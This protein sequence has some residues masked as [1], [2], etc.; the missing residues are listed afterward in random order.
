MPF[1]RRRRKCFGS[2]SSDHLICNTSGFFGPPLRWLPIKTSPPWFQS[3]HP[4]GWLARPQISFACFEYPHHITLFGSVVFVPKALPRFFQDTGRVRRAFTSSE[5]FLVYKGDNLEHFE[6]MSRRLLS[7]SPIGKCP[8]KCPTFF[9][10]AG[11]ASNPLPFPKYL[12]LFD[13][14]IQFVFSQN[15][16]PMCAQEVPC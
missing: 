15:S 6:I 8:I 1:V 16:P 10:L 4:L 14:S 11:L 3:L 5:A 2:K 13:P 9:P 12:T 7:V